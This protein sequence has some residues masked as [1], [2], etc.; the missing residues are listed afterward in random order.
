MINFVSYSDNIKETLCKIQRVSP[1]DKF[2]FTAHDILRIL[3]AYSDSALLIIEDADE[4]ALTP[5]EVSWLNK[6]EIDIIITSRYRYDDA[7]DLK[8]MEVQELLEIMCHQTSSE[9]KKIEFHNAQNYAGIINHSS[10]NTALSVLFATA[11]A[12]Y[13]H[14]VDAI[15]RKE[16]RIL[17]E[18]E[19]DFAEN[20]SEKK[21]KSEIKPVSQ[22]FCSLFVNYLSAEAVHTLYYFT[23]FNSFQ[24]PVGIM[25]KLCPICTDQMI[26]YLNRYHILSVLIKNGDSVLCFDPNTFY[27]FQG[28]ALQA[29]ESY[30][31]EI[32]AL[33]LFLINYNHDEDYIHPSLLCNLVYNLKSE[34]DEW[35][36][37]K[38]AILAFLEANFPDS[39]ECATLKAFLIP[40]Q[41]TNPPCSVSSYLQY[42]NQYYNLIT[43]LNRSEEYRRYVNNHLIQKINDD[44]ALIKHLLKYTENV[45]LSGT[46]IHCAQPTD[47]I[48]KI[49]RSY[50][51]PQMLNLTIPEQSGIDK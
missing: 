3:S 14:K 12:N 37:Y 48:L 6:S 31:N 16:P 50:L 42:D 44:A 20:N 27:V 41:N 33:Y 43:D 4:K 35:T 2:Q 30:V 34:S 9:Q 19:V 36:K 17:Y 5:E 46:Y 49:I 39:N 8:K 24:L 22:H 18:S 25:K 40:F 47:M 32:K 51:Y 23:L 11:L 45:V 15:L 29:Q 10:G 7:I 21:R 13:S 38:Y 26:D 1:Y 28:R